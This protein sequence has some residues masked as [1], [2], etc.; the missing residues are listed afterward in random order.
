MHVDEFSPHDDGALRELGTVVAQL[1]ML[2]GFVH[3]GLEVRAEVSVL[4]IDSR[5][6]NKVISEEQVVVPELY[7]EQGAAREDC[8]ELEHLVNVGVGVVCL[9]VVTVAALLVTQDELNIG[10]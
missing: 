8:L 1:A 5:L 6:A 9:I 3:Q 10:I 7:L 2:N 4:K